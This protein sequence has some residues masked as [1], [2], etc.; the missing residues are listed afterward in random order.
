MHRP[1]FAALTT[2]NNDGPMYFMARHIFQI[3]SLAV[4]ATFSHVA[5]AQTPTILAGDVFEISRAYQTQNEASDGSSSG[6]SSGRDE[7]H[8]RVIASDQNGTQFD[9]DHARATPPEARAS[10]WILPVRIFRPA[11]GP[12]RLLNREEL[13]RRRDDW[14]RGAGLTQES[15]GRWIFTWNAFQVECDPAL[16]LA[17]LAE[18]LPD[19]PVAGGNYAHPM[20]ETTTPWR[21]QGAG[22]GELLAAEVPISSDRVRAAWRQMNE[23]TAQILG[24]PSIVGD[25]AA[26]QED[27]RIDG[28]ISATFERA[29]AGMVT[30]LTEVIR[31]TA[32]SGDNVTETTVERRTLERRQVRSR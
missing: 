12:A 4:A 16:A 23:I 14:L 11:A 19:D 18:W 13:E 7:L 30:R 9:I 2:G 3:F 5:I 8:I 28:M 21:L 10:S 17:M 15:C 24:R 22:Q 25:D 32:V 1:L 6:S 27:S 29:E 20:S 31:R 26:E